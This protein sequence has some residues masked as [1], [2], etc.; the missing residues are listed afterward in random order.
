MSPQDCVDT[1]LSLPPT[2]GSLERV[3]EPIEIHMSY[4][5]RFV[6]MQVPT[7]SLRAATSALE[8]PW[9]VF[10]KKDPLNTERNI[11]TASGEL[12]KSEVMVLELA[13]SFEEDQH[14]FQR[15]EGIQPHLF[16]QMIDLLKCVFQL[17]LS[18]LYRAFQAITARL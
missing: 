7:S 16:A 15:P 1:S 6:L 9:R 8:V 13:E 3:V 2:F 11:R 14:F 12:S 10:R 17:S 5:L 18:T 4:R